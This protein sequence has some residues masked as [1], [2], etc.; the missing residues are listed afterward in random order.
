MAKAVVSGVVVT[1]LATVCMD[2]QSGDQGTP[3]PI[4]RSAA[5]A[6]ADIGS[7]GGSGLADAQSPQGERAWARMR[8]LIPVGSPIRITVSG[9]TSLRGSL[10]AADEESIT[11]TVAES[12]RRVTRADVLQVFA[13]S[14]T[15]RERHMSIG[16]I[17]GMAAGMF[18][19]ARSRCA[20]R[21]NICQE[22]ALAENFLPLTLGGIA[23]GA[24]VP[25]GTTWRQIYGRPAP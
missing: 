17:I 22:G 21:D 12:D 23:V 10:R 6:R 7:S 4:A 19:M 20:F 25:P 24:M 2:A 18:A 3:G 13:P 5:R 9:R 1:L 14:G 15:K 11:I 16:M 8:T